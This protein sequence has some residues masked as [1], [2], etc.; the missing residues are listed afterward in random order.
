MS[1]V[2]SARRQFSLFARSVLHP[3]RTSFAHHQE[4]SAVY[5]NVPNAVRFVTVA[6]G[7]TRMLDA[8]FTAESRCTGTRG[9]CTVRIV[10]VTPTGAVIEL[11]P[12][13]STDFA[14]DS[15][16]GGDLWEGHDRAH[17]RYLSAGTY[18][19]QVQTRGVGGASS[20]RLD[21]R[22]LAGEI[23]RPWLAVGPGPAG[24]DAAPAGPETASC[25]PGWTRPELGLVI[26]VIVIEVIWPRRRGA[27]APIAGA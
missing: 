21:D 15:A 16:T 7:T 11:D 14:F 8:R 26:E 24:A 27:S 19:V 18:R 4:Q 5:V 6:A 3:P 25:P 17:V 20:V 23:I 1:T 9:W 13:A 12:A 22:S 10:V 2:G